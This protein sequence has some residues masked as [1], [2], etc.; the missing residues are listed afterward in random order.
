MDEGVGPDNKTYI[1]LF[2][3]I[4]D[5]K[6]TVPWDENGVGYVEQLVQQY[7]TTLYDD[8]LSECPMPV[9]QIQKRMRQLVRQ[10]DRLG[11]PK[12]Q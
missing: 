6:I 3:P 8:L 10:V 1:P 2:S 7:A 4:P 11:T 9:I 12:W 5:E